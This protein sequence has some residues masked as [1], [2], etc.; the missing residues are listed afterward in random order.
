L[1]NEE[2]DQEIL[3]AVRNLAQ[4]WRWF[5]SDSDDEDSQVER[6]ATPDSSDADQTIAKDVEPVVASVSEHCRTE[7]VR[8]KNTTAQRPIQSQCCTL[9]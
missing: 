4:Q 2:S 7:G 6:E 5:L 8:E 1:V 9:T 3:D